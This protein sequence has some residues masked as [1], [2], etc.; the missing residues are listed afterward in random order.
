MAIDNFTFNAPVPEPTT[1]ALLSLGLV[2][3]G[4]A[5]RKKAALTRPQSPMS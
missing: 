1:F 3:L 4:F 5:R 2:G